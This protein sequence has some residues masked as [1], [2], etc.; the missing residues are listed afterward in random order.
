MA[1]LLLGV[2]G[3]ITQ[4]FG[5]ASGSRGYSSQLFRKH[6]LVTTLRV[7]LAPAST[8]MSAPGVEGEVMADLA[9]ITY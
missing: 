7:V 9:G 1:D 8:G 6:G 2:E 3:I 4:V 5:L